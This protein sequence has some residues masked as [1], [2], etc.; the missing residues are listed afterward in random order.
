Y[1]D[2]NIESGPK[3][4]SSMV[5]LKRLLNE[6]APIHAVG[7]QGHWKSGQVPFDDIEKAIVDYASLGLKVSITELDVTIRGQSGGQ[8]G[9]SVGRRRYP[10]TAPPSLDELNAQAE[11]YARLFAIFKKHE[12]V[13]ERVTFWGLNDRRTWRW[14]QHPLLLDAS[15][16]PKP[17]YAAIVNATLPDNAD[18]RVSPLEQIRVNDGGQ[19]PN[20]ATATPLKWS[21][22]GVLVR[23]ISD[24]SH[25]IV[26]VKD[27]TIVRH[28]GLWH[29]YATAYSTSA[30]T[31]SMVYLNFKEWDDAPNAKL[32]HIDINPKL[33]GYHCAPHLFYFTPHEKWYLIFQSQHPQYCT[34]DDISKPETWSAP[35]N[36][37]ESMPPGTPRLPIDYHI[38]CD[39]THAY[40]FFTGDDGNF[41]RCR[42]KI[43]DF[44]NGMSAPEIAIK[45]NRN[46]LF[47]GSMTYKVKGTE[48]YLT[49]IEAMSPARYYRA[50]TS[51]DL[52]GEWTP[53][54]GADSWDTPF[55]GIKNVTFDDGVQPWTRDI[56]H[57]ELIRDNVTETPTIDVGNLQFLFQGRDPDDGGPYHLLP[58]RLGL[59]RLDESSEF[60]PPIGDVDVGA[61]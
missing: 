22:S 29:I 51:N 57:G 12:D 4:E 20:S 44:P 9:G 58:Y 46:D 3:H 33:R 30:R 8:L 27:P 59:L 60:P 28:E 25:T 52:N 13:I 40:L 61:N 38:I 43:G 42:T 49:I 6:A 21:A 2:Y 48:T 26:S 23:P 35:Q 50:W 17:A 47:E 55:A 36:F 5:L 16:N 7:I 53:L 41:Y 11:D 24:E 14:G 32:T 18:D 19:G 45:D 10:T 34:A 15:N 54:P 39:A 1:N 37:F 56:S 31:W